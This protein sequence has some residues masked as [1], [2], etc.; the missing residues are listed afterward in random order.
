MNGNSYVLDTNIIL[1]LLSGDE[2][3]AWHLQGQP[4]YT[5]V[6]CEMELM[7]YKGFSTKEQKG[8]REFLDSLEIID[9]NESVREE[10]IFL[11]KNNKLRLPDAIVAGTALALGLPLLTADKQF[12]QIN[13]LRIDLY[14][15]RA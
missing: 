1:Y 9:I 13:R 15:P 3:I 11:R 6:I 8:I 7:S 12:R 10:T 5:S 2:M 14:E 4:L